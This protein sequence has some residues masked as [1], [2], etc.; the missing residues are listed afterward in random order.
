MNVR[1]IQSQPTEI[2]GTKTVTEKRQLVYLYCL[3][4]QTLPMNQLKNAGENL[5]TVYHN[6]L[7]AVVEKV[8]SDEFG[9]SGLK[10]NLADMTWI[11]EKVSLH[12][13][14]IERVMANVDVIP[15][16]FGI[17]FNTD[18]SLKAMLEQHEGEL[19]AILYKITNRQE[20]GIKIYYNKQKLK[21]NLINDNSEISNIENEIKKSSAGRNYFLRKKIEQI[22]EITLNKKINECGRECFELLEKMSF[23]ACVNRLLPKEVTER[24]DEMI[25]NSAFLIDKDNAT[26]FQNMVDILKMQYENKGF[27]LDCTGP[28]PPYNFCKSSGMG[29]QDE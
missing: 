3:T 6:N 13:E 19:E 12:E 9:E 28:W 23:D 29:K 7:C 4:H 20:W 5:Y 22:T 25:L 15:F 10:R 11:K 17:V 26:G 8:D 2:T 24:E 21:E 18:D 14:I 27:C 1:D 16:K